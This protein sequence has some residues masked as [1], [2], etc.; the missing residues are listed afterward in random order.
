MLNYN[1]PLQCM[2]EGRGV[3]FSKLSPS[4]VNS[5]QKDEVYAQVCQLTTF[6]HYYLRQ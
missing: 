4:P 3:A 2:M 6:Y 5:I 1:E